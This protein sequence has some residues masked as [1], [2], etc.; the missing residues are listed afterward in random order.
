MASADLMKPDASNCEPAAQLAGDPC[1]EQAA[2]E[3]PRR[4]P[5]QRGV[6]P[7]R[8]RDVEVVVQVLPDRQ[9]GQHGNPEALELLGRTDAREHQ[10]LGRVE[11]TGGEDDL[12]AGADDELL[13][14]GVEHL[15]ARGSV[16]VEHQLGG[17]EL[18]Q[19]TQVLR[20]AAEVALRGGVAPA[21]GR[22]DL[23]DAEASWDLPL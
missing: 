18:G 8:H 14:V 7:E 4:G 22:A 3:V 10:Q 21:L 5:A 15:D 20:C 13:A 17:A 16:A 23:D 19:Q 11:D 1:L 6:H 2:E 9:V 12:A